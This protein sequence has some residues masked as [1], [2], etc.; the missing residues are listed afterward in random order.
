M[1]DFERFND[2]KDDLLYFILKDENKYF[3]E[4]AKEKF[5]IDDEHETGLGFTSWLIH[6][7]EIDGKKA[8]DLYSDHNTDFDEDYLLVMKNSL[9][10]FFELIKT[11][12]NT[13]LK[14]I[15]T[16]KD[17]LLSGDDKNIEG[18]LLAGRIYFIK[19]KIALSEEMTTFEKSFVE[20]F[21]KGILEKYNLYTKMSGMVSID[22]FVEGNP[23]VFYKYLD[24]ADQSDA[25][26]NFDDD[27]LRV[28]Q[29]LFGF[30]DKKE[31]IEILKS[32]SH[33]SMLDDDE[34]IILNEG[35]RCELILLDN[36]FELECVTNSELES[37]KQLI[38][39]IFGDKVVHIGDEV[40]TLDNLL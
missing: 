15:I 3:V 9:F 35:D 21:R 37:F 19:D 10:S 34:F 30:S 40:I 13:I 8:V 22:D 18:E 24:V 5:F 17:Y 29:G 26:M 32:D 16:R 23:I 36:R 12:N 11:Q 38:S 7:C 1:F 27:D 2:F 14:D 4:K 6:D 39:E 33:I 20:V 31:I 25:I 28:Y